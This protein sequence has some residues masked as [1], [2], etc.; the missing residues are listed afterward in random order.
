MLWNYQKDVYYFEL[1]NPL[2][3]KYIKVFDEDDKQIDLIVTDSIM[4]KVSD[5]KFECDKW[6]MNRTV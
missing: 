5:F 2:A 3:R 1:W 4:N 6:Y